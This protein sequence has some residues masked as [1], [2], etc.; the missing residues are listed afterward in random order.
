MRE[1]IQG[2]GRAARDWT[3]EH[4]GAGLTRALE[5]SDAREL[6][7]DLVIALTRRTEF[8]SMAGTRDGAAGGAGAMASAAPVGV[9]ILSGQ[10]PLRFEPV[11]ERADL[12]KIA[13]RMPG[14]E[15]ALDARL[16]AAG[17]GLPGEARQSIATLRTHARRLTGQ[18]AER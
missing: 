6:G 17:R 16:K 9:F 15:D 10:G 4:A 18:G 8:H 1:A 14:L 2:A 12:S 5:L 3:R 7:A 13:A 11:E